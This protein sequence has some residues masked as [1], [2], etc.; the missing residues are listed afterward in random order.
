MNQ[1]R[2]D[3]VAREKKHCFSLLHDAALWSDGRIDEMSNDSLIGYIQLA[4]VVVQA[5]EPDLQGVRGELMSLGF[6]TSPL[7]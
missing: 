7:N 2:E 3:E 5:R 6:N 1:M 4:A